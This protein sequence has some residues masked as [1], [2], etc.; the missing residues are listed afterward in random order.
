MIKAFLLDLM[1]DPPFYKEKSFWIWT[2][3]ALAA[4]TG[5]VIYFIKK[6]NGKR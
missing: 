2:I 1:P 3:A 6:K 5:L 4:I